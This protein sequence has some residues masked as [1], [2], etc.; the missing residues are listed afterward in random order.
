MT[1]RLQNSNIYLTY[2]DKEKKIPG[3]MWLLTTLAERL[4][5][6]GT[7]YGICCRETAPSTGTLHYHLFIK[8]KKMVSIRNANSIIKMEGIIPHIEKVNNNIKRII[9]YIK[10]NGDIAVLNPENAP[11]NTM[12]S[13]QEKAKLMVSGDLERLFIDGTLGAVDII[14]AEK[15]RSIFIKYSQPTGYKQRMV[16]WFRG[17]TG[18]GKTRTALKIAE[19][20]YNNSYWL[21]SD[22]LKWFDGYTNQRVA[23]IDD[24]RKNMLTDWSFILRLLDGYNLI[25][26]IKGGFTK[27]NPELIIITSPATPEQAFSWTNKEGEEQPWDKQEQLTR[28]LTSYDELQVYEFPLWEQERVRLENTIRKRLEIPLLDQENMMPEEWSIIEPEGFITPG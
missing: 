3:P 11:K 26:Q 22:T 4:E 5:R 21:S 16:L 8:C 27:W 25:V 18:E 6:Y 2:M 28:R 7:E 10:K 19:Q 13:K 14:R 12:I 1:L 15:L 20:Y 24:F 23:I 17:E 9:D